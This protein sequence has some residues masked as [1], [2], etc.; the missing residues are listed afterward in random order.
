MP[1]LAR[2]KRVTIGCVD[3]GA[4]ARGVD[5]AAL[6]RVAGYLRRQGVAARIE[7][8]NIGESDIA[9]GDWLLSRVA[10]LGCD[11]IVMGGYGHPRWRERILGGATQAVLSSMTVPVLMSH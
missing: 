9:F 10:D 7:K 5:G 3:P 2:A 11:L 4:T 8:D 6:E 1:V